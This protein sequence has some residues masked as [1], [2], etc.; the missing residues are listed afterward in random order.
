MYCKNGLYDHRHKQLHQTGVA[1][2]DL[3]GGWEGI[4]D[5]IKVVMPLRR[6]AATVNFQK[7]VEYGMNGDRSE[8]GYMD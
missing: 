4:I 5:A 1:E 6:D 2:A 3:M 8:V 7:L